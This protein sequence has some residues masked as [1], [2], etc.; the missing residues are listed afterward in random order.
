MEQRGQKA[1][2]SITIDSLAYNYHT[3]SNRLLNVI[4]AVNDTATKRM[5]ALPEN[6]E[7]IQVSTKRSDQTIYR[8]NGSVKEAITNGYVYVFVSIESANLVYF[9]NLQITRER[10]A[11]VEETHYYPFGLTMAGISSKVPDKRNSGDHNYINGN[12]NHQVANDNN[13]EWLCYGV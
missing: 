11:I 13:L 7:L 3:N 12:R 4:D 5:A 6:S 2:T 9:D 1:V 8:I 10:G